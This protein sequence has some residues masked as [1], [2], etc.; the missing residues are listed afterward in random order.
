MATVGAAVTV[1]GNN[2]YG[3]G[4]Q[5]YGGMGYGGGGMWPQAHQAAATQYADPNADFSAYYAAQ[6]LLQQQQAA[7]TGYPQQSPWG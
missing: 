4:M 3:G 7:G 6:L 1:Q 5:A 2:P